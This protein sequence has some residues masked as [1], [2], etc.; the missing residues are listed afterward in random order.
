MIRRG[1]RARSTRSRTALATRQPRGCRRLRDW[2]G[3]SKL[4]L[5]TALGL[6]LGFDGLADEAVEQIVLGE[7][8][9]S[10]RWAVRSRGLVAFEPDDS[11]FP[12]PGQEPYIASPVLEAI[13]GGRAF[14]SRGGGT[15]QGLHPDL[16]LPGYID[17]GRPSSDRFAQLTPWSCS[18]ADNQDS[19]GAGS[20][21]RRWSRRQIAHALSVLADC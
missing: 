7:A 21:P 1:P 19:S 11:P 9:Q 12:R 6:A 18:R 14:A 4:P 13:R 5:R 2:F 16:Q 10:I 8:G 3:R 17:G 20:R 15:D